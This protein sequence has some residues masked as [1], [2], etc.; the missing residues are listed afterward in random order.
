MIRLS[1]RARRIEDEVFRTVIGLPRGVL[2]L[3]AGEPDFP[4]APFVNKAAVK[5]IA[6]NETHYTPVAGIAP[7][8]EEIARKLRREN[9]LSYDPEEIVVTPGV[10]AAVNLLLL[11]LID[12][13]DSVLIP[14]PSWFHYSTLVELAGGVPR[15][16]P[17]DPRGGFRLGASKIEELAKPDTKLLIVNS[18]SNPTGRVLTKHELEEVA[19]VSERLGI[20]VLS[21]EIY[22]KVVYQPNVHTSIGTLPGMRERTIVVNGFS[23]GYAMT[24]WRLGYVA[25]PANV[26]KKVTSLLGYSLLCASSVAQFAAIEALKNPRSDDYARKMVRTWDKRRG[27]VRRYVEENLEVVS[28]MPP[29]GAFYSWVDVSRSGMDGKEAAKRILDEAKVGVLPGYIFGDQGRKYVRISF[30]TSDTVVEEGMKRLC[31]VLLEARVS[32]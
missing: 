17:L 31:K 24:G 26:I 12:R 15:R 27:I 2:R 29:E 13:N 28:A 7:L 3:T 22:E 5:A 11:A 14:D 10:S 21:D 19:G 25:A 16:V 18:P 23:K 9:H 6:A 30:A 4:T 32:N 8:R 20:N 1:R